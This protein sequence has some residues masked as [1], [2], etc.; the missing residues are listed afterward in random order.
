MPTAYGDFRAVAYRNVLDGTEHLALVMG[1]VAAAGRS[2]AGALIRVHSECMTGDIFGSLRCD[3]G[4]QLQQAMR[5]IAAEGCGAVIYLRGHEGRGIGLGR[6]VRAYALQEQGLDTVDANT[7]LGLPVDARDY[8]VGAQVLRDLG[9]GRMRL[10]TNNP[11]KCTGLAGHG[12]EIIRR[13]A[14]PT[15]PNEHNVAYLKTKHERMGHHLELPTTLG[16]ERV[17]AARRQQVT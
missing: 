7:A 8:G 12:L 17:H 10:I 5:A 9:V 13:V 6:K 2:S 15:E 4:A 1:D 16:Q 11:A 14:L 3:C